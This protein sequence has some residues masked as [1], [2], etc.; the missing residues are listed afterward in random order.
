M[1]DAE[2]MARKILETTIVPKTC[3][4]CG[5]QVR[6]QDDFIFAI[7]KRSRG[8]RSETFCH[9]SCFL[10]GPPEEKGETPRRGR[11]RNAE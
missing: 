2:K 3:I 11:K 5:K 10:Y 8:Q 9:R 4:I 6:P 7:G 1:V